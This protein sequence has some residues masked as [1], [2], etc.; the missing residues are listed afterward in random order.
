[1]PD[2]KLYAW[3]AH[4]QGLDGSFSGLSAS[5]VLER[6]GWARSVGGAAPY[7]T[8]FSR[9]GIRRDDADA[10]VAKVAIQEL[11]CAR[12][13]TYVVPASD[14][15]LALAAGQ[16][17][18][19]DEMKVARKL[20]VTDAEI[21][22]LRA[23]VLKSLAGEPLD[24]DAI[25]EKVGGAARNLGPE[26]VKKGLATTLPVAVGLLQTSGE[27]RRLPVNGRLDQQ[28]YRYALWKPG[29]L[30]GWS[31]TQEE[32]FVELARKFFSWIG[33][34]RISEFEEFA[35]LGVKA[36]KSAVAPLNLVEVAEEYL[37][38]GNDE[39]EFRKFKAPA[40]PQYALISSIDTILL[41]HQG[42]QGR[43]HTILDRGQA[44]GE[45]AFDQETNSIAW[46]SSVKRTRA[47]EEAVA[48]ME[49]FIKEDLG[50]AR[51]VSLDSPKSRAPRIEELRKAATAS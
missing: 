9:A 37:I 15:A 7:L 1:M 12:G 31:K 45:W 26:G 14:Y 36:A 2:A 34:A 32:S 25:R 44:I 35:G 33:P 8:L 42:L 51:S 27:I 30:E 23:A 5:E 38:L 13:C 21:A 20:G 41:K 22:K 11:P 47:L 24:M 28:R 29:P 40:Q 17:F 6:A 39:A 43:N 16:P 49:N 50:D 4:R 18:A 48:R 19:G 46:A 3:W 10:G